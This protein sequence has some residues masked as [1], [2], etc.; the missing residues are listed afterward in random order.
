MMSNTWTVPPV[1]VVTY[2]V[3]PM[4]TILNICV[5]HA[6]RLFTFGRAWHLGS[7]CSIT[8]WSDKINL[9]AS[10]VLI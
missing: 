1:L 3:S 2:F 9:S 7:K 5:I 10:T 8:S 6:L 4:L